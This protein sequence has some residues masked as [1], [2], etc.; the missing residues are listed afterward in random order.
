M[1]NTKNNMNRKHCGKVFLIMLGMVAAGM[2]FAA[3]GKESKGGGSITLS[4]DGI[5][6]SGSGATVK[7]SKITINKGGTY[8]VSG[9]ISDGQ[10]VV[11]SDKDVKLV[12]E[13]AD[14]TN[15][16]EEAIF[17]KN[18]NVTIDVKDENSITNGD[19]DT[20][21]KI[22]SDSSKNNKDNKSSDD[23][24]DSDDEKA[25]HAAIY[26]KDK[27]KITGSGTLNV[28]GYINNGIQSKGKMT[29]DV[30]KLNVNSSNHGLKSKKNV[31]VNSGNITITCAQDGIHSNDEITINDGEIVINAT[32]DGIHAGNT[33]V[34]EK[35]TIDIQKCNEG[36][37]AVD[38]TVNSGDINIIAEDDGINACGG[39]NAFGQGDKAGGNPGN[40]EKNA[41]GVMT[42]G[43]MPDGERPALPEGETMPELSEGETMPE[44]PDGER[45]ELP[46]DGNMPDGERPALPEGE[47]MPDKSEDETIAEADKGNESDKSEDSDE[48]PVFTMNGGK[49]YIQSGG[50][51]I[52]SNGDIYIND[53]EVTIDAPVRGADSAI[54]YGI[55]N[56]GKAVVNAGT[57]IGLGTS[58]MAEEFEGD[59]SKQCSFT[60][61]MD[62]QI[63]AGTEISISDSSGNVIATFT[64]KNGCDCIQYS[65]DKLKKGETYTIMA[66]DT[67]GTI[68]QT[69]TA[70]TN[71]TKN[72]AGNNQQKNGRRFSDKS[73]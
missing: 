73:V 20:Y 24:K 48:S 40:N 5:T 33:L 65:S 30:G 19:K 26:S 54:D 63:S 3:C 16:S 66:G 58:A 15:E 32:D 41:G 43:N 11:N 72:N 12:L 35:G 31:I 61:V 52:D 22:I 14:I 42:P 10:I 69:D 1:K 28:N 8:N 70:V 67:T 36:L 44:R 64:T 9:S 53:G 37:E 25:A 34:I 7:K 62:S 49:I 29:V 23:D 71:N 56:G 21:D 51:G 59:S 4:D 2:L 13:G 45:P 6:F 46:E 60:Y 47:T 50:D 27:L 57:V 17:V 39:K 68:E 55:E 38:I 18:G